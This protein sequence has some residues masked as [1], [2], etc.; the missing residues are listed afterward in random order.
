[1]LGGAPKEH[2]VLAESE[3][4]L[5]SPEVLVLYRK[6]EVARGIHEHRVIARFR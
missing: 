6:R 3:I 4:S 2:D 5:A 1:M